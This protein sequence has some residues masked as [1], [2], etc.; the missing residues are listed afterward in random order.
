M[1]NRMF[2]RGSAAPGAGV[3]SNPNEASRVKNPGFRAV[4][5]AEAWSA[6]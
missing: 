3:S 5:M 6:L 1:I 4:L 2:G